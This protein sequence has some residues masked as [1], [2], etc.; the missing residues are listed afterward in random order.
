[1]L[2]SRTTDKFNEIGVRPEL[3]ANLIPKNPNVAAIITCPR[4]LYRPF[5]PRD[6]SRETFSQSSRNPTKPNATTSAIT[7]SAEAVMAVWVIP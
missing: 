6:F 1:M 4:I 5:R 7:K 3:S 2:V